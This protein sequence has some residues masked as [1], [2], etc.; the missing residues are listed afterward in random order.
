MDQSNK[1]NEVTAM[2]IC[3]SLND[4]EEIAR[5]II[6]DFSSDRIFAFSGVMGA[7]KTTFI[8]EICRV[9][10][11]ADLVSSPSFSIVNEYLTVHGGS[12]FHF[13]FYR[14]RNIGE[15]LDIGY[16]DYFFSGEYCFIEWPEKI[17]ELLPDSCVYIQIEV[18]EP[19]NSRRIIAGRNPG[20]S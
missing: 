13:D 4:L 15:V 5:N 8:R 19:D 16:E 18:L 10:G 2:Y 9:L 12:L 11:A 20:Q 1:T 17:G 6:R 3:R 14:I 7:G